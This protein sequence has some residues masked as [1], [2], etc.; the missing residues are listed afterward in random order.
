MHIETSSNIHGNNIVFI[1]FERTVYIQISNI[2]FFCNRF[3]ILSNDSLEAIGRF[4]IQLLLEDNTWS[5]RYNTAKDDRYSDTSP[6]WT[7]LSLV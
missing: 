3:S 4:G 6:H 5:T 1:S 2:T 7:K